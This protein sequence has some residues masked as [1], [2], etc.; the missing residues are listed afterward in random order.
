MWKYIGC[1][2]SLDLF[3]LS[4]SL[5]FSPMVQIVPKLKFQR[6]LMHQLIFNMTAL[7]LS[8]VQSLSISQS[9]TQLPLVDMFVQHKV[10][11]WGRLLKQPSGKLTVRYKW[12]I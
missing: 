6:S 2:G 1:K 8:S 9:M 4:V 3:I 11:Q 12:K 10:Y 7:N 5:F